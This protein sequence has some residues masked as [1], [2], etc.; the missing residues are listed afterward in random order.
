MKRGSEAPKAVLADIGNEKYVQSPVINLT[1][2]SP[3]PL[4]NRAQQG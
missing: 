2:F 1:D 3:Y 4:S